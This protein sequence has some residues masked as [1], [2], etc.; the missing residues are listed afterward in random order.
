MHLP[1]DFIFTE[2]WYLLDFIAVAG[3]GAVL[4]A[5]FYLFIL[6]LFLFIYFFFFF[7]FLQQ[8]GFDMPCKQNIS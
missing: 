7:I 8:I 6:F 3:H 5:L 2:L 4:A 1:F